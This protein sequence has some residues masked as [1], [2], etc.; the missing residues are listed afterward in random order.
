[1]WRKPWLLP[2]GTRFPTVPVVLILFVGS[3][4]HAQ[5]SQYSPTYLTQ[6][7]IENLM[8]VEVTSASK[9][10]Q[11]LSRVASAILKRGAC[12]KLTWQF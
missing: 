12:A 3:L 9:K 8:N 2:R 7:S 10:E 1:M 11:R 4:A 5:V 6:V